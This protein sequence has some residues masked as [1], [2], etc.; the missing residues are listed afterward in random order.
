MV[1]SIGESKRTLATHQ[2]FAKAYDCFTNTCQLFAEKEILNMFKISLRT[3]TVYYYK[4]C[5]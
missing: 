4:N 1:A 5:L 2:L 3:K